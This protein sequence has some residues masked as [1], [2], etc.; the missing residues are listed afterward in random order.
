M[1]SHL[2][3]ASFVGIVRSEL[4]GLAVSMSTDWVACSV[5]T[6]R[7]AAWRMAGSTGRT[8]GVASIDSAADC[9]H[10]ASTVAVVPAC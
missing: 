5:L 1:N 4:A 8:V 6:A 3:I 9:T 7:T 2:S 10:R